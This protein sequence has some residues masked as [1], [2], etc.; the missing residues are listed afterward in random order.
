MNVYN[1]IKTLIS[2]NLEFLCPSLIVKLLNCDTA[3]RPMK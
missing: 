1:F 2:A 3:S